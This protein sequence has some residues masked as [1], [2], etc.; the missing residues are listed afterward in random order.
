MFA[1][2]VNALRPA[3]PY[4][5]LVIDGPVGSGKT[6][7][8]RALRAWIDPSPVLVRRLPERDEQ[9]LPFAFENWILAFDDVYRFSPKIADALGA[10]SSGD[11]LRITQPDSREPLETEIARPIILVAPRDESQVAWA[12]P[13]A[14]SHRTLTIQRSPVRCVHPERALWS[15]F[16]SL[17]PALLGA[18]AQAV[19]TALQRIRDIDLSNVA[20]FPDS[21]V[22]CAAAAPALGLTEQAAIQ[23]VTDPAAMWLGADPLRDALRTFLATGAV[24]TGDA[25]S[26]LNQ[27][28][29]LSPRA[30]LP[31]SPKNLTQALPGIFGF[32]VERKRSAPDGRTLAVT[33][34]GDIEQEATAGRMPRA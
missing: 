5:I 27:L 14:L 32:R 15:E 23:A 18:L 25:G 8:A 10:V 6:L 19:V 26:L 4:P 21:A 13:R 17:R 33:R 12:P 1:W 16:E 2:L 3:G 29:A 31:A 24:W 34:I 11:A 22:W 7:L 20:R 30:T 28:R 9:V